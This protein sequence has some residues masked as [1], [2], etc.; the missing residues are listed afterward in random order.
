LNP[1]RLGV[2]RDVGPL[3]GCCAWVALGDVPRNGFVRVADVPRTAPKFHGH[4]VTCRHASPGLDVELARDVFVGIEEHSAKVHAVNTGHSRVRGIGIARVPR[5]VAGVNQAG[6]FSVRGVVASRSGMPPMLV[7]CGAA[8]GVGLPRSGGDGIAALSGVFARQELRIGGLAP[9][10]HGVGG[11]GNRDGFFPLV[12]GVLVI[13][14]EGNGCPKNQTARQVVGGRVQDGVRRGWRPRQQVVVGL[15]T[16]QQVGV[17]IE[18]LHDE[19]DGM[20]H[21]ER[22]RSVLTDTRL[23]E[24]LDGNGDFDGFPDEDVV[25]DGPV[26]LNPLVGGNRGVSDGDALHGEI[27]VGT[28]T[29]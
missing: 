15:P 22:H 8:G 29:A 23:T 11:D 18:G 21:F 2:P 17:E 16:G 13:V 19:A 12:V 14:N 10:F 4:A 5:L 27:V 24:A 28:A 25:H 6:G 9:V 7:A 1:R 3:T 26:G 20:D